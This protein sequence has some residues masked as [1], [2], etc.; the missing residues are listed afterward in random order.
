MLV[1]VGAVEL[2][3]VPVDVGEVEVV[4]PELPLIVKY[5]VVK[6]PERTLKLIGP[7]FPDGT[8]TRR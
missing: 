8:C 7:E 2:L 5:A 4:D 3:V 1:M 6:V